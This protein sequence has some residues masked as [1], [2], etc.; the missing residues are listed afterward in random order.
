MDVW[1]QYLQPV[2]ASFARLVAAFFCVQHLHH[3]PLTGRLDAF[4]QQRLDF[5]QIVC[6]AILR[7]GKLAFNR[8]ERLVEK[9]SS[10]A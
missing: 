7:K 5:L 6:I 4:F 3:Q 1:G 10:L 9:L 2:P 8:L